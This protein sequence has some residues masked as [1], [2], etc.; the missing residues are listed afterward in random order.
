M[1]TKVYDPDRN[2]AATNQLFY[3]LTGPTCLDCSQNA[4]NPTYQAFDNSTIQSNQYFNAF[5]RDGIANSIEPQPFMAPPPRSADYRSNFVANAP[6]VNFLMV[7]VDLNGETRNPWRYDASS[8]NR[9]N[10]DSFDLWA[11]YTVGKKT[12]TNGNW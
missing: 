3:E 5:N 2:Y 1:L 10:S 7:P 8:T 9:H 11:V 4:A 12:F 6:N